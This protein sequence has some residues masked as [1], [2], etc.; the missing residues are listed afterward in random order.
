MLLKVV[1]VSTWL[2]TAEMILV[3]T[4]TGLFKGSKPAVPT[5]SLDEVGVAVLK[6]DGDQSACAEKGCEGAYRRV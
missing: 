5:V 3:E 4:I 2:S 1:L 6:E